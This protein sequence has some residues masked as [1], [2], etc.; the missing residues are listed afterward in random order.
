MLNAIASKKNLHR[1]R[2]FISVPELGTPLLACFLLCILI[3]AYH[4]LITATICHGEL[5]TH[6]KNDHGTILSE[7]R[8]PLVNYLG[9]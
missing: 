7:Y 6:I 2:R 1:K 8:I 4:T 3:V 9:F 5:R